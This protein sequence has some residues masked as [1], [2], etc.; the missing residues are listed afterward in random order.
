MTTTNDTI[1][2]S[3]AERPKKIYKCLI[4]DRLYK[5][6]QGLYKHHIRPCEKN[7]STDV[8]DDKEDIIRQ[9]II[10]IQE[11][12]QKTVQEQQKQISELI[13]RIGTNITNNNHQENKFNI[14]IFL[15]EKCKDAMNISDFVKSIQL[16]LSDMEDIGE[17]GYVKGISN[18]IIK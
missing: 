6:R 4:C 7:I 3:T 15:N 9:L 2:I 1:T 12:E 8:V 17:L 14:N 11:Q 18:I 10:T 5:F 16:G 13:P